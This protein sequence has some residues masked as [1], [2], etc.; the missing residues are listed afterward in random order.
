MIGGVSWNEWEKLQLYQSN[1]RADPPARPAAFT[2]YLHVRSSLK[3]VVALLSMSKRS[4]C[5]SRADSRASLQRFALPRWEPVRAA[6]CQTSQPRWVKM[7]INRRLE[8]P[9]WPD[10][11]IFVRCLMFPFLLGVKRS[12]PCRACLRSHQVKYRKQTHLKK[13]EAS[14]PD[15]YI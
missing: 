2:G 12:S 9:H 6:Q 10:A 4:L 3:R 7:T 15:F 14:L 8:Q 1:L 13:A 11:R 5:V